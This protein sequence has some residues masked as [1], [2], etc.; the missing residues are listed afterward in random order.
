MSGLPDRRIAAFIRRHHVMSLA[1]QGEGGM[2]CAAVF[3]AWVAERNVF[4]YA[5][6][7]DTLHGRQAAANPEVSGSIV[8]ET[9]MVGRIQGLQLRGHTRPVDEGWART[10]YLTRFPYAA[11]VRLDLWVLEPD[12]MKLSD[13]RL[14]FGKKL[15]WDA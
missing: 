12:V 1:T 7:P 14:G 15:I 9:R 6:D 8:L 4:V 3:Y 11:A 5:T 13:N 2:W 10:A